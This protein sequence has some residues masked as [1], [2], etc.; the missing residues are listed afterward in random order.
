MSEE[1]ENKKDEKIE[2]DV[3][4]PTQDTKKEMPIEETKKEKSTEDS[5]KETPAENNEKETPSK[6]IPKGDETEVEIVKK[7]EIKKE[8]EIVKEKPKNVF[9][10]SGWNP[11]TEIGKKVKSQ[12]ITEIDEILD[13]GQKIMEPEI[14][15]ILLPNCETDLLLIGQSKGKFGGGQRR[16]FKQTQK[17]TKEGNKPKF[18]TFA[19]HGNMDGYVGYGYGKAKETVPAREKAFRKAK[20]NV[21]KIRRGC[22]SWECGCGHYHSIPYAVT[23]KCSSV[24]ITL[25]PAPKGTGLV[26]ESECQKILKL[27][28]IKDVWSKTQGHTK[29]KLNL[30]YACLDALHNLTKTKIQSKHFEKL[31]IVEG[32]RKQNE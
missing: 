17:K 29:T 5:G 23:G 28:G 26:V 18:A 25:M 20:L 21:M 13:H 8:D 32:R 6:E 2:Q 3:K 24:Q 14:V 11:K 7:E 19:I 16:I 27:A 15:D 4:T 1:K 10:S 9:D 31:S 22:G 30:I 12:E